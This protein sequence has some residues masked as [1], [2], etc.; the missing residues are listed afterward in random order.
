MGDGFPFDL[1]LVALVAGVLGGVN[2]AKRERATQDA[3]IDEERRQE[4][5]AREMADNEDT[6]GL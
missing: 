3:R 1:V 5:L 6:T 4:R 2:R